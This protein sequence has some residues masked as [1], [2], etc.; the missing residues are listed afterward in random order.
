MMNK[1]SRLLF[2]SLFGNDDDTVEISFQEGNGQVKI[3]QSLK[4]NDNVQGYSAKLRATLSL[5]L[6]THT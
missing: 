6:Q 4:Y 1:L 5:S 3:K 2:L